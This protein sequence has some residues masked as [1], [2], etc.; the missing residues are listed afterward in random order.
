MKT[1]PENK[2]RERADELEYLRWFRVNADFGPADGDVND[3]MSERF[4]RET[5]K[6]LP[7]G[8]NYCSDGETITDNFKP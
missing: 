5:G 7:E 6:D 2:P 4:I 3:E 1:E 8:W